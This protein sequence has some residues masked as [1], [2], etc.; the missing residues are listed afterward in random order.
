MLGN[1]FLALVNTLPAGF[2]LQGPGG[3]DALGIAVYDLADPDHTPHWYGPLASLFGYA[4]A[5]VDTSGAKRIAYRDPASQPRLVDLPWVTGTAWLPDT[6]APFATAFSGPNRLG[7]GAVGFS[8]R[9]ADLSPPTDLTSG[10]ASYDVRYAYQ[11]LSPALTWVNPSSWRRTTATSIS[12]RPPTAA[13]AVC[14]QVR[15][16]DR[17]GNLSGWTKYHCRRLR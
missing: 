7:H 4:L 2:G 13:T 8:Y 14:F 1:G 3:A 11:G 12:L 6:G 9:F 10:V 17:A 16:R 15:A 5:T